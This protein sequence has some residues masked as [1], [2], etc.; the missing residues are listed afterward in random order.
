MKA[1]LQWSLDS[2]GQDGQAKDNLI[3]GEDGWAQGDTFRN[4]GTSRVGSLD[5]PSYFQ[6]RLQVVATD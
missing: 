4:V 2:R 6:L 5:N 1:A 3:W